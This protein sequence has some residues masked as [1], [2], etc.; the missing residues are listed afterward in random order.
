MTTSN[1][2]AHTPEEVDAMLLREYRR[3][4]AAGRLRNMRAEMQRLST[5]ALDKV[6][7]EFRALGFAGFR[8]R[9]VDG[10]LLVEGL[11]ASE[12]GRPVS[13][14]LTEVPHE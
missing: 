8:V 2:A 13:H 1:D 6:F 12:V 14:F 3:D 10:Q 11:S 7:A 4:V 5:R 9:Q